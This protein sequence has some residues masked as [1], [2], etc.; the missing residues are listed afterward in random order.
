[1]PRFLPI[2]LITLLL[3]TGAHSLAQNGFTPVVGDP[4]AAANIAISAPDENGIVTISGTPNAVF[5]GAQLAIRN[6][7]TEQTVYVQAGLTGTFE[8]RI[9]G[10]GVTPFMISPAV[11]IPADLRDQPGSLPGGPA[12]IIYGGTAP[13]E[14]SAVSITPLILDG[15]VSD[16]EPISAS[17]FQ[18][19]ENDM[20]YAL[21][22]N[23]S[24]YI[25][26]AS[27]RVPEDY[28]K[29][30][31]TYT[32]EGATYEALLDPRL[33]EEAATWKRIAPVENDLGTLGAVKIQGDA[34]EIRIPLEPLRATLGAAL[35]SATLEQ[36]DFRAADNSSLLAIPVARDFVAFDEVDGL[37][38]P[39]GERLD[40][41]LPFTVSGPVAQGAGVWHANGRINQL[42]FAPGDSLHLQLD[43]N[44]DAP[45][46]P[47]AL[48]GL[49]MVGQLILQPVIQADGIQ[50]TGGLNSNNGWST[51]LTPSG[52][53]VDNLRSDFL[54]GEVI[55]P[56][57]QV[58]R[59][60]E[61]LI[62]GLD[63]DLSLPETLP[64]GSYSLI[65][66]GL[67]QIGNG[68]RFQ[69]E[70]NGLLGT[71]PSI[72]RLYL[73]RL[74]LVLTIGDVA[75]GHLI[76]NLLIDSPS[77]GS[78]GVLARE[79]QDRAAL[80]NRVRFNSPT[81]ILP[82]FADPFGEQPNEYALEPYLM[83][84]LPNAYDSTGAPMIPFDLPGGEMT[85]SVTR[86]DGIVENLGR[87]IIAQNQLSTVTLNEGDRFGRQSPLDIFRLTT[88]NRR[89]TNF[90]LNQYGPYTIEV[91]GSLDD[92]WGNAYTGGGT[93]DV[94]V[95]ELF[96]MQL[97][98]LSGTPFEVGDIYY[99]GLQVSPGVPADV[100]V[101]ARI[102]PLDGGRMVER[103]ISGQA[104][105]Y[106]YFASTGF[107]LSVPGEYVVDY[108][109]RYTDS[110][111]R[112]WAGSYRSAGVIAQPE[113]NLIAHGR[114][115]LADYYPGTR[116]AWF[117]TMAYGPDDEPLR[118]NYPY[119]SGDVLWYTPNTRNTI[120]PAITVQDTEGSYANWL[121]GTL[122]ETISSDGLTMARRGLRA[123]LPVW[124]VDDNEGYNYISVV[125]PGLTVRQYVTG[126]DDAGLPLYWDTDDPY[127]E[128]IGSGL[129]GDLEGDF[130]FLFGGVVIRNPAAEI[131]E[132]AIYGATG[133]VTNERDGLG[134]RVYPP[135]RGTAGGADGGPLLT[136]LDEPVTMFFHPTAVHPGQVL[137]VGDTL[138]IAGQMA[139]ALP[140]N[141]QVTVTDPTGTSRVFT[142]VANAI[143]Y[144]YDPDNNL[145]VDQPGIWQVEIE[146]WHDGLTSAGP[147]D[148]SLPMGGILGVQDQF[149]VYV[150][151]EDEPWL[152]WNDSR[153]D[154]PIPGA[155]PY[156]F[157]FSI[158]EDWVN[159]QVDH[160][161]TIP[162]FLLRSGPINV[163][164]TSFSYQH[165]PTNLNAIFPNLEVDARL[166]GPAA[167]DPVT[168]TFVVTGE[169]ADGQPQIRTRLFTIF[170]DRLISLE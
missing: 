114:R 136:I 2:V 163:N 160:S 19:S 53:A 144:F 39:D 101:T 103:V 170:Y 130:V 47:E 162:G 70:D 76:W 142:G 98:V 69:W 80:S 161:V 7:Y 141:I 30:S 61:Q 21:R 135:Y 32:L 64:D 75:E 57:P 59:R 84:Q 46:L 139:P 129:T 91:A 131:A 96:D 3:L 72:S 110:D 40:D 166:D 77:E 124:T 36:L 157:N 24:L 159:P 158:P 17:R 123:E 86:P 88:L 12:T 116:P 5:P 119:H 6:L 97:G 132:T 13:S 155:L 90:Q 93:Y 38:Y 20:V 126:S 54:L 127:N 60:D 118:L 78:R 122:G 43:V 4:P 41:A 125:R 153:Q 83:A 9:F 151:P 65:F 50:A 95:A 66:R 145:E 168:L 44:L 27:S 56:A 68:E 121:V 117:S 81:Y 134:A 108:E 169:D 167:A 11:N 8:T 51:V 105:R 106:G 150:V 79:D 100:T 52:L 18:T 165:N 94:L 26:L 22:N 138:T 35:E 146:I 149:S 147:I 15:S 33:I 31:V 143:G 10:P 48:V 89:F 111:G 113:N 67:G 85:I 102:Y 34:I 55:V 25:A 133:F 128:Q 49:G 92:I 58:L 45:D 104:N 148:D 14:S 37:F 154:F 28:W 82:P 99:P 164:G 1:M 156:N 63:F 62:F 73:T 112:L 74:P 109:A 115:G 71:G 107:A 42:E 23:Q 16:W 140:S 87:S 152:D 137:N 120:R 29:L